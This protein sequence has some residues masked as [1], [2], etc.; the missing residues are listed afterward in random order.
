V[1][2]EIRS[3]I[4]GVPV[5]IN[6]ET[7][8]Y[9][10]GRDSE[11]NYKDGLD[12]NKESPWNE[13]VN[14][15][16]FNSKNKGSYSSL[17]MEK[18]MM[19]KIQNEN[20]LPRGGVSDQ[21]SLEHGVFLHFFLKKDKSNVPKY[22]FKHMIKTLKES[23]LNNKTWILY[24]R[25][26]AEIFNQEGLLRG[27]S[28][29]RGFNDDM[30][31]TVTGKIINGA[32]L[33]NMKLIK[34]DVVIKLESDMKESRISSNLMEGFPPICKQDPLDVQLFYIANHL[35]S[36]GEEIRLEDIPKTM[37]GGNAKVA[38]SRKT[39]RKPMSEAEYLEGAS[40]QPAKKAKKARKDNAHEAT[41]SGVASIQ[42][43]V[44]DLEADKILLER[45]RSGKA[46]TTSSIS[47]K[48]PSIP[49]R[50]RKHVV[51]KL[52]ESK[53][54][55]AEEESAEATELVTREVRRKRVNDEVV[56]RVVELASQ[57]EVP[58]SNL[59]REDAVEAA[60]QVIESAVVVQELAASEAEVL[61]MVGTAEAKEGNAGTSEALESQEAPEGKSDA[62]H[63]DIDIVE[64]GSS[65]DI[66]TNSPSTSSSSISSSDEDDIPLSKVYSLINKTP[67]TSTKTTQKP[68]D[69]FEP[70]YPSVEERMIGMQQRR[71]QVSICRSPLATTSN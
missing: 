44:E 58:A 19:L 8:A 65:S 43:E 2:T 1:D 41:G 61:A 29:T 66:R 5:F 51:R 13:V 24:G 45:T 63:T 46:A 56:Q 14:E 38:K 18:K 64:V 22:I 4:M 37:Y 27:L 62:L 11:G 32:T 48:Q 34:P 6:Q 20:L 31:G 68:D 10:I 40:E 55:E 69:T 17:S 21:P 52:K 23:Q 25:L 70:M 54:V 16:M 67:S 47:P 57:I 49:K 60:Q 50:E 35:Q 53:Y 59:A 36:T 30:L 15:T 12:N 9:V 33:A 42:E 26:I 39:K 7:I 28:E 71:I 3:S